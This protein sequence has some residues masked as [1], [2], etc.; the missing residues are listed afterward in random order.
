VS[1][2]LRASSVAGATAT[3]SLMA[4]LMAVLIARSLGPSGR[5][6]YAIVTLTALVTGAFGSLGFSNGATVRI[7]KSPRA[8]NGFYTVTLILVVAS[9]VPLVLLVN[10]FARV[11]GLNLF[12]GIS[13]H[14]V[15]VGSLA[16]PS[17]LPPR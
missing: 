3:H 15:L 17:W 9:G 2:L 14:L 8:A 11:S 13:P 16:I 4:L 6:L 1:F 12:T 7:G 5:G 10:V